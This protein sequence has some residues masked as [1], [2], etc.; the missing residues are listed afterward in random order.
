[1]ASSDKSSMLTYFQSIADSLINSEII[2][3]KK[4]GGKV[5]GYFCSFIPPE[6]ISAAG[7]LP[8]RLRGTGSTNTVLADNYFTEVS[9]SFARHCF[10]QALKKEFDF[11]DGLIAANGCD[12]LRHMYENWQNANI[13]T[14]F[15]YMFFRPTKCGKEMAYLFRYYLIE[16]IDKLNKH[17][18]IEISEIKLKKEIQSS[19]KTRN[20]LRKLYKLR[21]A[22]L[23]PI[24]GSEMVSVMVAETAMQRERYNE[25]LMSLLNCLKDT[26]SVEA[27]DTARIMILGACNDNPFLCNL[28]EENGA[29]VVTDESCFGS[30]NIWKDINEE[31]TDPLRAISDFYVNDRP[32][33]PRIFGEHERR[34]KNIIEIARDYNVDGIIGEALVSCDMYA[35][36]YYMLRPKLKDAGYPFLQL[37]KEY[38]P[39]FKGQL[40]TRVQAFIESIKER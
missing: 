30:R 33:C 35:S 38:I 14:P 16:L 13:G 12:H 40:R 32:S 27:R 34:A 3:W 39:T 36:E 22:A 28:I 6:I 9:C 8:F 11:L 10:N 19:N 26:K 4:N 29:S 15:L 21:K 1:M 23:Q 20:L 24:T 2:E 25:M 37:N 31:E 17:F 7:L 18:G 5:I